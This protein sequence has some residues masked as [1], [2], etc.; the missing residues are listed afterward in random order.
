MRVLVSALGAAAAAAV[1]AD[2]GGGAAKSHLA[3]EEYRLGLVST[4]RAC[5]HALP[6]RACAVG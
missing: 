3:S 6:M 4:L 2:A 1:K 5:E